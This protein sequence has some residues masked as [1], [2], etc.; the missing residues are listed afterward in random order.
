MDGLG[1]DTIGP[2]LRGHDPRLRQLPAIQPLMGC[3]QDTANF[4]QL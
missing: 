2:V 3:P 1:L 4:K